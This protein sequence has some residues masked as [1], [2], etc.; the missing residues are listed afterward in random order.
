MSD[1]EVRTMLR[2]EDVKVVVE[3]T[4]GIEQRY[5]EACLKRLNKM[6]K[7]GADLDELLTRTQETTEKVG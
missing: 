5:T 2:P 6:L 7:D 4:E 1:L 3:Y